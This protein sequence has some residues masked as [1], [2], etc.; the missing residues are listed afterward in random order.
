MSW[1]TKYIQHCPIIRPSSSEY[2]KK[3]APIFGFGMGEARILK[4]WPD[5]LTNVRYDVLDRYH[6]SPYT[7]Y[8]VRDEWRVYP[9]GYNPYSSVYRGPSFYPSY[10]YRPS[11]WYLGY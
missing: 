2:H 9:G 7:S 11:F 10:Q 3:D 4:G 6:F 5:S 8:R 1:D